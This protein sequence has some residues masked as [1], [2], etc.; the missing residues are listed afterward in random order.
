[1]KP[2]LSIVILSYNTKDL[3]RDCLLSLKKVKTEADFDVIVPDNG[4]TDSSPEMVEK[5]FPWIKKII[6]IGKNIGFAAGNNRALKAVKSE[7]VLLL[8]PDTIVYPNTIK[9]V[10]NYMEDNAYV[11]AATC[12]VELPN[13]KLDY[14]CHRGFPTPWNA[15]CYFSGLSNIFPGSKFFSG[16][17]A[18]YKDLNSIHEVDAL[19][20]AFAMIRTKAGRQVGWFDE[21]YF[22]NGEDIDFCYKLKE[23]KWKIIYIPDVKITHFKGSASGL[24]KTGVLK[25]AKFVKKKAALSSTQVMRLFYKKHLAQ[26]YPFYVNWLVYLGISLLES[27][28]VSKSSI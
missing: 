15:L 24:R 17:T 1:M 12:R 18:T 23:R 28:R 16:Y 7:F 13:G 5:E 2:K 4:S 21:D 8:N 26:N 9:R 20:G 27:F 19:T 10:L 22:W 25:P 14:S 6:R 3:L 11:G